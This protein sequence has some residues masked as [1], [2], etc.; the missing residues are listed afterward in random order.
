[1]AA[2][3]YFWTVVLAVSCWGFLRSDHIHSEILTYFEMV[4]AKKTLTYQLRYEETSGR[5]Q[6]GARG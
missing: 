1:L 3:G 2:K 5:L 6:K 4:I